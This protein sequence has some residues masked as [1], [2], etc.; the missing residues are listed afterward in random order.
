[1]KTLYAK[2]ILYAYPNLEILMDQIDALVEK[3]ALGSMDDYTPCLAQCEKVISLIEQKKVLIL[4]KIVC[5][6]ILDKFSLEQKDLLDYK[7]FKQKPKEYY[8]DFDCVSRG[9][10]R[11]QIRVANEFSSRLEKSGLTDE[12]FEENCLVNDFFFELCKRIKQREEKQSKKRLFL[13]GDTGKKI[14]RKIFKKN[15]EK[16]GENILEQEK[17]SA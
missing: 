11:R 8:A 14:A 10:F 16:E 3:K 1:M 5:D 12:W 13:Q 15:K 4:L 9:Y 2:C 6:K 17:M 7:Y